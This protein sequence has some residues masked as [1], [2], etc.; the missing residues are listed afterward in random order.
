MRVVSPCRRGAVS[1][2]NSQQGR[3]LCLATRPRYPQDYNVTA[4]PE[5]GPWTSRP[6]PIDRP[7]APAAVTARSPG[8]SDGAERS[9][10]RNAASHSRR[11]G[12]TCEADLDQVQRMQHQRG[13]DAAAEPGRQ[14]LQLHV[15]QHGAHGRRR[16]PNGARMAP[17][18]RRR[19]H[20]RRR[21]SRRRA[22]PRLARP[23]RE[24]RARL[25]RSR[26]GE[27]GG[28][29]AARRK[30]VSVPVCVLG[31]EDAGEGAEP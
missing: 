22:A 3:V 30:W 19:A 1:I 13:H 18:T 14:V 23:R 8:S 27:G 9:A 28:R 20:P 7:A 26:V 31:R 2:R 10:R 17:G 12:L 4:A 6:P 25:F 16:R 5:G 24:L 21:R 29:W 15:P 11:P